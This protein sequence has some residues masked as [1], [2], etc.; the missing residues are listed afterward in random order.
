MCKTNIRCSIWCILCIIIMYP[1]HLPCFFCVLCCL[2]CKGHDVN[3]FCKLLLSILFG[4]LGLVQILPHEASAENAA[5]CHVDW[6]LMQAWCTVDAQLIHSWCTL[7]SPASGA[8]PSTFECRGP[9]P[10]ANLQ[11]GDSGPGLEV[12]MSTATIDA[13]TCGTQIRHFRNS[14]D[15]VSSANLLLFCFPPYLIPCIF[16]LLLILLSQRR[17]PF[18]QALQ[19]SLAYKLAA[20]KAEVAEE[21]QNGMIEG[22]KCKKNTVALTA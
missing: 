21:S 5:V 19:L 15:C 20:L 12:Q 2:E 17:P 8:M 13:A 3:I 14:D 4:G 7:D 16:Q 9:C 6:E 11:G 10:T 22:I 1:F 18:V